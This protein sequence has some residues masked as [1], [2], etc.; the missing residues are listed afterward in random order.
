MLQYMFKL[1]NTLSQLAQDLDL[2][3]SHD[4]ALQ[5]AEYNVVGQQVFY[6]QDDVVPL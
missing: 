5:L 4:L 3:V 1:D 6:L 2:W